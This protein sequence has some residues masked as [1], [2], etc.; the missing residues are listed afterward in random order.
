MNSVV[1]LAMVLGLVAGIVCLALARLCGQTDARERLVFFAGCLFGF[2]GA[3]V[4]LMADGV[5]GT[6]SELQDGLENTVN[7][8]LLQHW[9]RLGRGGLVVSEDDQPRLCTAKDLADF[10]V[11]HCR[12]ALGVNSTDVCPRWVLYVP[13]FLPA[14]KPCAALRTNR[15]VLGDAVARQVLMDAIAEPCSYVPG[16]LDYATRRMRKA[17]GCG[18]GRPLDKVML[19]VE[20]AGRSET[21]VFKSGQVALP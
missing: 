14:L 12:L 2:W 6:F 18:N 4:V 1:F 7:Y 21:L 10:S 5:A 9:Q 20:E 11:L 17:L 19:I 8:S 16:T 13:F 3:S 15:E